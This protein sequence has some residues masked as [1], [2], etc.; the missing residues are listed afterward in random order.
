MSDNTPK[1]P[2]P[3]VLDRTPAT[4]TITQTP[5]LC[6]CGGFPTRDSAEF[7]AGHDAKLKSALIKAHLAGTTFVVKDG[8]TE[9]KATAMELAAERSWRGQLIDAEDR[10][11]RKAAEKAKKEADKAKS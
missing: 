9:R 1:T 2:A 3:V 11:S 4:R 10:E 8:D 5:C 6:G 7:V